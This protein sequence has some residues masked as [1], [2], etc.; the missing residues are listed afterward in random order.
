MSLHH[1]G[2]TFQISAHKLYTRGYLTSIIHKITLSVKHLFARN[3]HNIRAQH[4]SGY[5]Q[6]SYPSN[7]KSSHSH[8]VRLNMQITRIS[9]GSSA[10]ILVH[11]ENHII[12]YT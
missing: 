4:E 11:G 1:K 10:V 12:V 6:V 3:L 5:K 8:P 7:L 9:F 2:D